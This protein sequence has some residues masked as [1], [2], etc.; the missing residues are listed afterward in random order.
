M[1]SHVVQFCY[2]SVSYG[3]CLV[4]SGS[5]YKDASVINESVLEYLM[6]AENIRE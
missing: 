3:I 4:E 2:L 6:R 1:R 5:V